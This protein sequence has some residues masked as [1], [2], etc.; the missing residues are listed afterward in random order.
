M[1]NNSFLLEVSCPKVSWH[2]HPH[3]MRF[4]C[5]HRKARTSLLVTFMEM[6]E[7]MNS[8][9]MWSRAICHWV[10]YGEFPWEEMLWGDPRG[11][12][13]VQAPG[14][15]VGWLPAITFVLFLFFFIIWSNWD[16]ICCILW[17]KKSLLESI[18]TLGTSRF[19][20][21]LIQ[22]W[23]TFFLAKSPAFFFT[24]R[25]VGTI[26]CVH[27]LLEH[28]EQAQQQNHRPAHSVIPGT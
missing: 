6:R 28:S 3:V 27:S 9:C 1:G 12:C 7:I 10:S 22:L 17:K 14:F 5:A 15:S 4:L 13:T 11:P 26:D 23:I 20:W 2:R 8:T 18:L 21:L 19:P 24:G 16:K 25:H